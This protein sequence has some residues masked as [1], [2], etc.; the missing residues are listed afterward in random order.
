MNK[1]F[2]L[3]TIT[4]LLAFPALAS[5]QIKVNIKQGNGQGIPVQFASTP[6]AEGIVQTILLNVINLF[7]AVGGIGVIIFFVWGAVD[8]ILAGGDKEKIS[9][10]RKKMTNAIIGL[11]L[12]SLSFAIIRTVGAI[13]GFDPLGNLQLKGLGTQ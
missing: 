5:A 10:A 3:L 11:I 6:N 13:A 12:L 2:I 4:K 8:W 9:G 1:T 7:F